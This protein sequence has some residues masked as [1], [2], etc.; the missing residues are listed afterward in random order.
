MKIHMFQFGKGK[1]TKEEWDKWWNFF[2]SKEFQK[3]CIVR[4]GQDKA[5]THRNNRSNTPK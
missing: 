1:L 5:T 3:Y 2:E 4:E